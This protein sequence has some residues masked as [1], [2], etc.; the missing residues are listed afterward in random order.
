MFTECF[1]VLNIQKLLSVPSRKLSREFITVR[2][3]SCGKVMFS[4][5]CVKN[6]VQGGVS[7]HVLGQTSSGQ[8]SQHALGQ[9]PPQRPLQRTVRILL[10]C[11][12]VYLIRSQSFLSVMAMYKSDIVIN[13]SRKIKNEMQRL[14]L[15]VQG[16]LHWSACLFLE[17]KVM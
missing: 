16:K 6:S 4:Q 7:Q 3:S 10:E 11:F 8:V 1:S 14:L 12:L 2:N 5:A 9:T 17:P 15:A 13:P